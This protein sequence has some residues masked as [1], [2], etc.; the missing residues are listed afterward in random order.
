MSFL[1][2]DSVYILTTFISGVPH[3]KPENWAEKK[4]G[5]LD[6][7]FVLIATAVQIAQIIVGFDVSEFT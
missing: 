3:L 7:N 4:F 2:F 1:D 5:E 6:L